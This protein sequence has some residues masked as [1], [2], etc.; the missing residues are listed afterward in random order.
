MDCMGS[1]SPT[2][3][4]DAGLGNDS[5][6]WGGVQPV[7]AK[8]TR[9]CAYDRA[10]WGLSQTVPGPQDAND[11]ADELHGLLDAAG[12][13]GSVVLM[14]HSIAGMYI[15][16]YASRYPAQVAGLIFVDA[17]TPLQDEGS[18]LIGAKMP[19]GSPPGCEIIHGQGRDGAG[20]TALAGCVFAAPAGIFPGERRRACRM[21]ISAIRIVDAGIGEMLHF[22]Q[23][24]EGDGARRPL[25]AIAAGAGPLQRPSE[26]RWPTTD[27]PPRWRRGSAYAGER[28]KPP[29]DA[30]PAHHR[31]RK[32]TISSSSGRT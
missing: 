5:L 23:S 30:Q 19:H 32:P 20:R 18:A 21:R 29:F 2:L 31:E 4:L 7:L 24:G 13:D 10:G 11:I 12:I 8:N 16:A 25:M 14:G 1:G 28:L 3:I 17:S 6:I 15:R 26:K 27:R 22:H 9:V